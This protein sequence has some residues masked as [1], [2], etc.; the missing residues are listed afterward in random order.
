M[1]AR[2]GNLT[3]SLSL[4]DEWCQTVNNKKPAFKRAFCCLPTSESSAEIGQIFIRQL[5]LNSVFEIRAVPFDKVLHHR[6]QSNQNRK[7]DFVG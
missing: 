1:T 3:P 6:K 4:K 7:A 2:S 5:R